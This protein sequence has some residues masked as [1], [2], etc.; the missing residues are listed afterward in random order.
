MHPRGR[1]LHGVH[2]VTQRAE[3]AVAAVE[4]QQ[5][6]GRREVFEHGLPQPPG[7]AQAQGGGDPGLDPG[8]CGVLE[9]DHHR[10]AG[11]PPAE[12]GQDLGD[13]P[14]LADPA[15]AGDAHEAVGGHGLQQ[16]RG[17]LLPPDEGA[18]GRR[19]GGRRS[20]HGRR[21]DRRAGQQVVAEDPPLQVLQGRGGIQAQLAGEAPA[22]RG[23]AL[24]RLG[25]PP[26][27]VEGGHEQPVGALPQ[28]LPDHEVLEGGHRVVDRPGA[29]RQHRPV[30]HGPQ[31]QLLQA[32]GL[33]GGET[34]VGELGVG[35]PAPQRQ[36]LVEDPGRLRR[37][38]PG[39]PGAQGLEPAG[40]DRPGRQRQPVARR[41]GPHGLSAQD[42]AQPRDDGV[43]RPAGAGRSVVA[44]HGLDEGVHGDR[45]RG[46]DDERGEG[47][48]RPRAG[49]RDRCSGAPDL[50]RPQDA[51][52]HGVLSHVPI[53]RR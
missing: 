35:G 13:E 2:E 42:R 12:P 36:R 40:V 43:Q 11:Q 34:V 8:G 37:R 24:E 21:G 4:D 51:D 27:A 30:L 53:V 33:G 48:A 29:Q 32:R 44:P 10:R 17:L 49:Q 46:V 31:A 16:L 39:G 5:E 7:G 14:G 47:R 1:P 25:R 18:G 41:P 38:H 50:E 15:G 22:Q 26:G 28:R 3:D 45:V 19:P 23:V 9:L 20:P 52:L 6:G